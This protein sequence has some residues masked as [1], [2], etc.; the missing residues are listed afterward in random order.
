MARVQGPANERSRETLDA[1]R[2]AKELDK[3]HAFL[4]L[5][6]PALSRFINSCEHVNQE[7]DATRVMVELELFHAIH[8]RWPGSLA[9]FHRL[10]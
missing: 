3:R 6:L 4:K 10:R 8:Q 2:Y 9:V 1:D 5:V 7:F